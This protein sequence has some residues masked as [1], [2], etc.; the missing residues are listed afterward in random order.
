M[1]GVGAFDNCQM[2]D[3]AL[4]YRGAM[5]NGKFFASL[6]LL[7][8]VGVA[9]WP[10][11]TQTSSVDGVSVAVTA[12][13]LDANASIWDFA[14]AFD[15]RKQR[16]NDELMESVVLIGDDQR[17]K[18]LAWEGEKAGGTHRA[19]VMK[20]IAIQPRPK[21]LELRIT[22]PG[23]TKPRVFRFAFGDWSA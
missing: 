21:Q 5:G 1:T 10:T 11:V 14:I 8:S 13:T 7:I 3:A 23:E 6:A 20:F 18:P 17:V 16:I 15:S 19:G 4:R 22:R 2:P 9:A 12:G